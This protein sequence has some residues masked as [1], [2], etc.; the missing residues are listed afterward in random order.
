MRSRGPALSVIHAVGDSHASV[1][2]GEERLQACWPEPAGANLAGVKAWHLGPYLAY[3]VGDAQ[4]EV[5][6]R[7]RAVAKAFG[8]RDRVLLCFGEIDCRCHVVKQARR[9]GKS[10]LEIATALAERYARAA[11]EISEELGLKVGVWAAV[12][13]APRRIS[14]GTYRTFG[15]VR[16]RACATQVLNETLARECEGRGVDFVSAYSK[17]VKPDGTRREKYFM[18]DV[19][20]SQVALPL[21]RDALARAGWIDAQ[22]GVARH[23]DVSRASGLRLVREGV[24]PTQVSVS[25]KLQLIHRAARECAARGLK[26]VALLGAGQHVRQVTLEP[27]RQHGLRV[28]ALVDDAKAARRVLGVPVVAFDGVPREVQAVIPCSDAHEG[29]LLARAHGA[30]WGE[31]VRIVPVYTY[32]AR[33][34]QSA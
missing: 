18:D 12:P 2:G 25:V 27:Y 4:H 29:A 8:K 5:R 7:L 32:G 20:L 17:L 13:T 3:S 6:E 23:I 16:E 22:S 24:S 19:H 14:L 10:T 28:V 26:R 33:G 9:S 34:H 15:S 30:G 1:F 31:R 21:V 11:A